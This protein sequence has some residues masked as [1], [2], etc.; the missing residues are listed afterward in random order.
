[1]AKIYESSILIEVDSFVWSISLFFESFTMYA[2]RHIH[3]VG[4]GGIGM[5]GI[6]KI[7]RSQGYTISGCDADLGQ[8]SVID[9]QN[10]GCSIHQ[11]NN[12]PAC[13]DHTIDVLVYSTAIKET[14][15]EI[16][17][18]RSRGIP[19]IARAMMK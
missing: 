15:E 19:T 18:A 12:T 7:L 10:L 6:A 5:S 8:K 13:R 4:I 11:G 17:Y 9:L 14:N 1:M 2:Q 3:F 16:V